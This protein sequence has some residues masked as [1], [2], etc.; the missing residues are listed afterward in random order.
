MKKLIVLL[1]CLGCFAAVSVSSAI[2]LKQSKITQVVNDVQIISATDQTKKN[3][4]VN[5]I[6]N[7]P[8]IL[9][10]GPASRAEL[11]AADETVTRVGANMQDRILGNVHSAADL[12]RYATLFFSS[13]RR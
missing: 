5:D 3:A 8:D 1:L 12:V 13:R 10:T 6:F 9:R 11:V 2:D 4:S 7:M